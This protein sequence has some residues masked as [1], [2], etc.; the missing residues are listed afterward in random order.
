MK[1]VA[2]TSNNRLVLTVQL[3]LTITVLTACS[4]TGSGDVTKD[5]PHNRIDL[6]A[7]SAN[8]VPVL[9]PES[10]FRIDRYE[11]TSLQRKLYFSAPNQDPLTSVTLGE[12]R[13]ICKSL[14]K[15]LCSEG[16]W[17][18]ACLGTSRLA[19][20]YASRFFRERC[21]VSGKGLS[22]TGSHRECLSD[23]QIYDMIGNAMEWVESDVSPTSGIVAGGSYMSGNE[24]NCFTRQIVS[25]NSRSP[26][27]G[28]RCC[29]NG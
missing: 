22:P 21:N 17:L 14:G 29:G 11:V 2:Q 1:S 10:V 5:Q 6:S 28:F 16:Q 25:T 15:N 23:G 24:A 19:Y 18:Q 27:V 9:T 3:L 7:T 12:A 26:Q 20:G 4:S 8:M 13:E